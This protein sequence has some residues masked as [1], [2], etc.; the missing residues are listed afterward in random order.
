MLA[1]DV[2]AQKVARLLQLQLLH[3]PLTMGQKEEHHERN[4]FKKRGR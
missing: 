4:L 2:D 3:L 1:I